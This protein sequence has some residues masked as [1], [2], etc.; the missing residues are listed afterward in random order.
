MKFK[1][2]ALEALIELIKMPECQFESIRRYIQLSIKNIATG[3][4]FLRSCRLFKLLA[5]ECDLNQ[6]KVREMFEELNKAYQGLVTVILTKTVEY[7]SLY[8]ANEGDMSFDNYKEHSEIFVDFLKFVI[9]KCGVILTNIEID[10]IYNM[11]VFETPHTEC[12]SDLIFKHIFTYTNLDEE[13]NIRFLMSLSNRRNLFEKIMSNASK[14]NV[15]TITPNA[16]DCF[17]S[18]FLEINHEEGSLKRAN[19]Q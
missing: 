15:K 16:Y 19:P 17:K 6:P 8:L 13:N 11:F 18:L 1:D 7:R 4:D 9:L 10:S 2:Q 5:S 3:N 14:V 12:D